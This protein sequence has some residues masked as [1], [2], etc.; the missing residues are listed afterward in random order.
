MDH[1]DTL[2]TVS[3]RI[4]AVNPKRMPGRRRFARSAV[5]MVLREEDDG[6]EVLLMRRA[7]RHGDPWSGHMSFPGGRGEEGDSDTRRTAIRETSEETGLDIDAHCTTLGRMSDVLTRRHEKL[8]PMVV[9]PWAFRLDGDPDWEH[10]REVVETVWVPLHF[11][12]DHANRKRMTW[13]VG[14]VR[15]PVPC[16]FFENRRIWGLTL[17]MLDELVAVVEGREHWARRWITKKS[18]A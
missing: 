7:K 5:A 6:V 3:D 14:R 13:K 2:D 10:N 1:W 9:S 16:Y 11:F 8:A 15:M 12:A 17:L 18:G 4:A